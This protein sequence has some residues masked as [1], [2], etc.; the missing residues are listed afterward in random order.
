M[1][2]AAIVLFLLQ[3][4]HPRYAGLAGFLAAVP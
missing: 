2:R 1:P 4:L 3:P